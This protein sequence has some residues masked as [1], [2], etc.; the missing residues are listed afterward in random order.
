ML[1]YNE[2]PRTADEHRAE[3]EL[4]LAD[5]RAVAAEIFDR[6][7]RSWFDQWIAC[8]LLDHAHLLDEN[9]EAQR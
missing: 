5:L 1:V 2:P 7:D 9:E 4:M 3:H 8:V 6:P